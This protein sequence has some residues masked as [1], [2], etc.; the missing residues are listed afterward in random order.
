MTSVG[1]GRKIVSLDMINTDD[2]RLVSGYEEK[3]TSYPF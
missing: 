1:D 3:M 2:K